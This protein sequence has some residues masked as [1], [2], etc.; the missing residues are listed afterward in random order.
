MQPRAER[1]PRL[2]SS[3]RCSRCLQF[4]FSPLPHALRCSMISWHCT[5]VSRGAARQK[6]YALKLCWLQC[7][8]ADDEERVTA[9]ATASSHLETSLIAPRV[10]NLPGLLQVSPGSAIRILHPSQ[11]LHLLCRSS[12]AQN[13]L[14]CLSSVQ[15]RLQPFMSQYFAMGLGG[16]SASAAHAQSMPTTCSNSLSIAEVQ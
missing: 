11:S 3:H 13:T 1:P 6:T 14:Q 9:F 10:D 16:C 4:A 15:S 7:V 5:K 12:C 2:A 8:A